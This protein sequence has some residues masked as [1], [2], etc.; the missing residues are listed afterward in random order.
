MSGDS[1]VLSKRI[2][3]IA[4]TSLKQKKKVFFSFFKESQRSRKCF[5]VSSRLVQGLVEW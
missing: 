5:Q 2:V 3:Q 4:L 1:E